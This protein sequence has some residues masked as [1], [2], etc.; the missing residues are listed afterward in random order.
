MKQITEDYCSF[1]IVKLLKEKGFD[2]NIY[3]CYTD[4][5]F[6]E[7]LTMIDYVVQGEEY[8]RSNF[9]SRNLIQAPTHQMTLKWLREV[10]DLHIIIYPWQADNEEKA[11]HWCCTVYRSF[12]HLGNDVYTNETPKS[13]EEA[14]EAAILYILKNLI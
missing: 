5:E 8:E 2:A 7:F 14:V 4:C 3:T 9:E 1:E 13:Y 12:A 10:H 6:P 11:I